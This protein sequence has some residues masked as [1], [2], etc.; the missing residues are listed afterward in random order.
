MTP[1]VSTHHLYHLIVDAYS[2]IYAWEELCQLHKSNLRKAQE[3]L[4]RRLIKIHD[5]SEYR[6]TVVFDGRSKGRPETHQLPGRFQIIYSRE[7]QTADTVI[8]Q[9]VATFSKPEKIYVITDDN[10][11][12]STVESLGANTLSTDILRGILNQSNDEYSTTLDR[13]KSRVKRNLFE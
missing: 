7:G 10:L 3:E 13:V 2:V 4:I 1:L 9:M 5:F 8:E 6:V 11:E 12:R